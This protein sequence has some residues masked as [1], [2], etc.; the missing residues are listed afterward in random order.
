MIETSHIPV[1]ET[2]RLILRAPQIGDY[3][4]VAAF[5]GSDRSDEPM[6]ETAA[7]GAFAAGTGQWALRG[8]GQWIGEDRATAAPLVR[9]GIYHPPFWPEPEL[10]WAVLD[11]RAEG[12][13]LALEAALAARAAAARLWGILRPI[14][15]IFPGNIRS[16]TLAARLGAVFERDWNGP[17]GPMRIWRHPEEA[18]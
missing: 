17:F 9:V 5:L 8:Y 10:A 3:P 13:G 12:R 14:S 1:I 6:G 7:W 11:V 15:S 18:I 4:V 2:E 16:E